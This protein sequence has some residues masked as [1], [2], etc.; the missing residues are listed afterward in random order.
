MYNLRTTCLTTLKPVRKVFGF[1]APKGGNTT[2]TVASVSVSVTGRSGT[3]VTSL[4]PGSTSIGRNYPLG[5]VSMSMSTEFSGFGKDIQ[6]FYRNLCHTQSEHN[7]CYK[8]VFN[9]IIRHLLG[10]QGHYRAKLIQKYMKGAKL[11]TK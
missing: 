1:T 4:L 9:I 11:V 6:L 7:I 2:D 3:D 8:N 5:T 10:R